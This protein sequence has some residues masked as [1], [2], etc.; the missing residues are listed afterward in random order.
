MYFLFPLLMWCFQ[1][2]PSFDVVHSTMD[3][4]LV[5][6]I[7]CTET[8]L[9]IYSSRKVWCAGFWW[10]L[11]PRRSLSAFHCGM[12]IWNEWKWK[13]SHQELTYKS[14]NWT[15]P[16]NWLK[17]WTLIGCGATN[18][19]ETKRAHAQLVAG[20]GAFDAHTHARDWKFKKMFFRGTV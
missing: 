11:S 8:F 12:A 6:I 5:L 20:A 13:S 18:T 17:T 14:R 15:K 9:Y 2:T 7:Q 19:T 3:W 16:D 1:L 4:V 10:H